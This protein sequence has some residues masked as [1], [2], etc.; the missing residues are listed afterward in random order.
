MKQQL[1]QW[2]RSLIHSTFIPSYSLPFHSLPSF[3]PIPFHYW[4]LFHSIHA[5][6]HPMTMAIIFHSL[7]SA[8]VVCPVVKLF[9]ARGSTGE[10]NELPPFTATFVLSLVPSRSR[11][12][13]VVG[14][15]TWVFPALKKTLIKGNPWLISC[16][17]KRFFSERG[18]LGG[19]GRL[20][21]ID[22]LVFG[23]WVF[24]WKNWPSYILLMA[25]IP[26]AVGRFFLVVLFQP[27]PKILPWKKVFG[28]LGKKSL[29][30]IFQDQTAGTSLE[31]WWGKVTEDLGC[32]RHSLSHVALGWVIYIDIRRWVPH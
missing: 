30:T 32:F 25:V 2:T 23:R 26:V 5:G 20:A 11:S 16:L 19:V 28:R 8:I 7:H 17:I 29:Q 6:F 12:F 14:F 24:F 22:V 21:I 31:I 18:M 3:L 27:P 15:K 1:P 13:S 4:R 9:I 10:E